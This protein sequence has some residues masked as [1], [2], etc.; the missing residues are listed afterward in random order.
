MVVGVK[1]NLVLSDPGVEEL[2]EVFGC[3]YLGNF[4]K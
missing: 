2:A 1:V 3:A 4:E